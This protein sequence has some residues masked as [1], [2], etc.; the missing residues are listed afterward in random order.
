MYEF[1]LYE[2]GPISTCPTQLSDAKATHTIN[3]VCEPHPNTKLDYCQ[4]GVGRN[5]LNR[6][7]C[8][9]TNG[10]G[11]P[12]DDA[13]IEWFYLI[14]TNSVASAYVTGKF[15]FMANKSYIENVH[16]TQG[17]GYGGPGGIGI[18]IFNPSNHNPL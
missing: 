6:Y 4:D 9:I 8:C 16:T 11:P 17:L 14:E 15:T 13:F 18:P 10:L 1:A 7:F 3:T 12:F 5:L 2:C